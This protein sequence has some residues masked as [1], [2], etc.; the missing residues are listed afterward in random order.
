[1]QGYLELSRGQALAADS[2]I[3]CGFFCFV[4]S[5]LR[6][7]VGKAPDRRGWGNE[8]YLAWMFY[9][10]ASIA[11]C[12]W[13][14]SRSLTVLPSVGAALSDSAKPPLPGVACAPE[15]RA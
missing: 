8:A 3:V 6:A 5:V 13:L 1:M 11:V 4:K 2:I 10:A 9:H 7:A 15:V 12:A 14:A